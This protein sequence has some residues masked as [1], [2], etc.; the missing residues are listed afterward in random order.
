M[1]TISAT[2]TQKSP[3]RLAQEA[4]EQLARRLDSTDARSA[5]RLRKLEDALGDPVKS[6][7]WA[8]ADLHQMIDPA[9]IVENYKSH[10][11]PGR[12]IG[13]VEWIRNF[14]ILLPLMLTWL[15]IARA[16]DAYGSL[17]NA[18]NTL[19]T[20]PFLYLWQQ[21]FNGYLQPFGPF[22]FTLGALAATDFILLAI[23]MAL[24]AFVTIKSHIFNITREQEAEALRVELADALANTSFLLN[25]KKRRPL[26][27]FKE[28]A[29][30]LGTIAQQFEK[31]TQ[32][33]LKELEEERRDRGDFANFITAL[34]RI[35]DDILSASESI[36]QT[37]VELNQGVKDLLVPVKEISE[38]QKQLV[39][40]TQAAVLRLQDV[41]NS[42]N[43]L[44]TEHNKWR[45]E[46]Q[47]VLAANL[48]TLIA[49]QEKSADDLYNML[50]ASLSHLQQE[51]DRS[52]Q[53]LHAILSTSLNQFITEQGAW[54]KKFLELIDSLDLT[55]EQIGKSVSS[56][57]MAAKQQSQLVKALENERNEQSNL[58][59]KM[60]A[61]SKDTEAAL[62]AIRDWTPELYSIAVDMGKLVHEIKSL[63]TVIK[64]ELFD[65]LKYYSSAAANVSTSA[66]TLQTAA[67]AIDQASSSLASA[68]AKLDGRL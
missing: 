12:I 48:A 52:G 65:A 37:S 43:G 41:V 45:Q 9:A 51:Q 36:E 31:A 56:I 61:I 2:P 15:G 22:D 29:N 49:Q 59:S 42:L 6:E 57:D 33:F 20:Q 16:V 19:V 66:T 38:Q 23:I 18:D 21:K 39:A 62:K 58:T 54:G 34:K 67:T 30:E 27:S 26:D 53:Q 60:S 7:Q 4:L 1:T 35:S 8:D 68:T 46:V 28:V 13:I 14:A 44:V 10:T 17:L 24:T 11:L 5:I 3:E 55:I 32:D 64:T 40:A 63:P 50:D 47:A 25:T